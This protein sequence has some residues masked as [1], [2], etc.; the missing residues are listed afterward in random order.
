M[1]LFSMLLL[2]IFPMRRMAVWVL[3]HARTQEQAEMLGDAAWRYVADRLETGAVEVEELDGL[4][5]DA[6]H[7]D[8]L[9]P[10]I[11]VEESRSGRVLVTVPDG[12]RKIFSLLSAFVVFGKTGHF[13]VDPERIQQQIVR[14]A[15]FFFGRA[16]IIR[17]AC[18]DRCSAFH[19]LD[20]IGF[21]MDRFTK[22]CICRSNAVRFVGI[23]AAKL[24]QKVLSGR[25][26]CFLIPFFHFTGIVCLK[27]IKL[28]HDL[29]I[30][31]IFLRTSKT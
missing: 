8:T 14:L 30:P 16:M 23:T 11:E 25:L 5:M 27:E 18:L 19:L 2:M 13:V 10:E 22:F 9:K 29:R 26:L 12:K 6:F 21:C 15:D 20:Q 17:A 3:D 24:C 4:S 31:L 1:L 7:I 28:L